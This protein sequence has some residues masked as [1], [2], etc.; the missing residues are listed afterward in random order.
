MSIIGW[1]MGSLIIRKNNDICISCGYR[2][3]TE[4]ANNAFALVKWAIVR[5]LPFL[6]ANNLLSAIKNNGGAFFADAARSTATTS[7]S[8]T[9]APVVRGLA[10]RASVGASLIWSSPFGPLRVDYYAVPVV[11]EDFDK[12]QR[13]K[14]GI[15]SSLILAVQNCERTVLSLC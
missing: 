10:W 5:L 12:T 1:E 4:K 6:P 14:F 13:F 2:I 9:T 8:E 11:K 7:I 15:S 3:T